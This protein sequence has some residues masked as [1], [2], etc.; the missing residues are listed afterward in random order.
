ML[1][2]MA[3][4]RILSSFYILHRIPCRVCIPIALSIVPSHCAVGDLAVY[5]LSI[6]A[7]VY[8][9][10][11]CLCLSLSVSISVG[12]YHVYVYHCPCPS[13]SVPTIV[14]YLPYCT[15]Y[16]MLHRSS[17]FTDVHRRSLT[18]MAPLFVVYRRSSARLSPF[19]IAYC[20]LLSPIVVYCRLLSSVVVCCRLLSPV[21]ACCRLLS[22][23]VCCCSLFTVVCGLLSSTIP[24]VVVYYRLL[25][26]LLSLVVHCT[27]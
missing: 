27:V 25:Y 10:T 23:I 5:N 22:S 20:R 17:T 19:I 26:L 3:K 9:S 16:Y 1:P 24:F 12:V 15:A 6:V 8:H 14:H 7:S 11:V 4:R 21:V 2:T 13:L 18:S